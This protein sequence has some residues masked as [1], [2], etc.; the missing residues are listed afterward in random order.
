MTRP[1]LL[2]ALA[3]L[4]GCAGLP[5]P[6]A[7]AEP[8]PVELRLGPGDRVRVSV[9]GEEKLQHD[10]EVAPD[11]AIAFPLIGDVAVVGLTLDE[12]RIE[13]A[14]R[15]KALVVDPVVSVGLLET[16][17]AV[18]HVAGEVVRPG[19]VSFVRGASVLGAV[20][21]AGGFL[22]ATADLQA[23]RVVRDRMGERQAYE[24]DLEA[25]LAGEAPDAWLVPGDV[26]YVP[27][28]L[29]TRWDRWWRQG[30]FFTRPIDPHTGR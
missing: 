26:V 11:G 9:W 23:V 14:Q 8:P 3:L 22:P 25:V 29:V 7:A 5:A 30:G 2:A 24:V 12:L 1:L 18:V 16:R 19:V 17:S 20:Q 6:P 13:L 4:A 15:I 27:P 28:R 21:A 10:L